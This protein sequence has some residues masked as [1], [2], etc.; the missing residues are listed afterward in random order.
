[1]AAAEVQQ[2]L[3]RE[4]FLKMAKYPLIKSSGELLRAAWEGR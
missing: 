1:M 4:A 3:D 2:P